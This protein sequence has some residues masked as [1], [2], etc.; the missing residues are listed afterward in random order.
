M[1]HYSG[2]GEY[3]WRRVQHRRRGVL[4]V[5]PNPGISVVRFGSVIARFDRLDVV[6]AAA[7]PLTI[8]LLRAIRR[9]EMLQQ[10][11]R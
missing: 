11:A 8:V 3:R 2:R 6:H 5:E 7:I 10:L 9:R 1:L 4:S